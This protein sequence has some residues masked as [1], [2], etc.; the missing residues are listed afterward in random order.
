MKQLRLSEDQLNEMLAKSHVRVVKRMTALHPMRGPDVK[1]RK[2]TKP[3][4][5][6]WETE[7]AQQITFAGLP[8]PRREFR[9]ALKI[10][11]KFRADLAYPDK[12]LLIEIDGG[13]HAVKQRWHD[14]ILRGQIA[15][16]L[17]YRVIVVLPEQVK[18]GEALRIIERELAC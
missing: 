6:R 10:G 17:G 9:F 4:N 8:T 1:K 18:S 12:M 14:G 13:C 11:R 2:P 7:L 15:Q 16:Q 5:D 3:R